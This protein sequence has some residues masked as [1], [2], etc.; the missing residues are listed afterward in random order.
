ML[1]S[2]VVLKDDNKKQ[3]KLMHRTLEEDKHTKNS[4]PSMRICE[5]MSISV[6]ANQ[7]HVLFFLNLR[8]KKT[9]TN[10][11]HKKKLFTNSVYQ[12]IY[13]ICICDVTF[14]HAY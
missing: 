3:Q 13:I 10:Y 2:L 1:A 6:Y 12:S 11:F 14:H 4:I 5:C 9:K 8:G 7:K